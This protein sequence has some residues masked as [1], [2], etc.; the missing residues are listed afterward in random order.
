MKFPKNSPTVVAGKS[1]AQDLE[2]G[3]EH[4][5]ADHAAAE[6]ATT[7]ATPKSEGVA[8]V[9]SPALF[10]IS[11]LASAVLAACGGGGDGSTAPTTPSPSP[12]TSPSP[13]P[14]PSPGSAAPPAGSTPASPPASPAP[15]AKPAPPASADLLAPANAAQAARFLAQ[16]TLGANKS[17]IAALQATSYSGWIDAQFNIAP[18]PSQYSYLAGPSGAIALSGDGDN[19]LYGSMWR[20]MVASPDALRQRITYALSEIMVVS[21]IGGFNTAEA[22]GFANYVDRL[23]ANAFG[24]FR[25]LLNEVT[26]SRAMGSYLTYRG[27]IKGDAATGREPDE[28]YA[29]EVMQLFTLGLYKLNLNGT[30]QKT[31]SGA[32]IPTYTTDDVQGLARVF[33][34]WDN[35]NTPVAAGGLAS[36]AFKRP[37]VQ[38]A[39]RHET[40]AKTFLGVTI[41]AGVNGVDSL[42]T[43]LDTLFDHANAA[44]FFS[45]QLIQRLVTSNPSTAYTER[46]ATAFVNNGSGVRGDMKAVIRA[47]LLDTEARDLALAAGNSFGKLRE[48]MIRFTNWARGWNGA[49]A[50][51]YW[52]SPG[53]TASSDSLNQS[54][55]RATSVFNFFRPG[56]VPP[57]T[58]IANASLVAPEFQ[59]TTEVSVAGYVNKMVST[60]ANS[61]AVDLQCDYAP[62]L[63]LVGDSAALLNEINLVMAAEQVSAATLAGFKTALDTINVATPA[64]K[65]NRIIAAL[66]LIAASPEYIV[67]K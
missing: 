3:Q 36:D 22:Y 55:L 6:P 51:G 9:R 41:P 63:A 31:S 50:S 53:V 7:T 52:K 37:M 23:E 47:V 45:K 12:G 65:A 27:N 40:G 42:K 14:A 35:D 38:V 17:D 25:Q 33:T 61:T 18:L 26:L 39:S 58:P 28:N 64:G 67:L 19:S 29:R 4:K 2:S 20:K 16:A 60:F 24:N 8:D 46:V 44:P 21:T 59:I 10:A 15:P 43:A 49:S 13:N 56:Y 5:L 32:S 62:L 34:G 11:A 57:A 54:P 48:P 1:H 30:E 66:S